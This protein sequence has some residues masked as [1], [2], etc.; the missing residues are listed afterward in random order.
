MRLTANSSS[1]RLASLRGSEDRTRW[2]S[3]WTTVNSMSRMVS[4]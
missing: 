3:S 1:L 4:P 2:R